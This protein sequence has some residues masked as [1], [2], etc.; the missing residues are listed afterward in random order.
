M[1]PAGRSGA[2]LSGRARPSLEPR[3]RN[4][5][6]DRKSLRPPVTG[7]FAAELVGNRDPRQHVAEAQARRSAG[8]PA[9][10]HVQSSGPR[11]SRPLPQ[12]RPSPILVGGEGAVFGRVGRE[13]VQQQS[14]AGDRGTGN[15]NVNSRD[16]DARMFGFVERRHNRADKRLERRGMGRGVTKPSE[17]VSAWAR[18][19]AESRARVASATSRGDFA[20][21][22]LKPTMLPERANRLLTR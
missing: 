10:R 7:D 22:A 2:F 11:R 6:A 3:S 20:E 18:A 19:S 9:A 21:R 14:E 12:R 15:A 13:F 4:R 5:E 1:A 17:K 16:R 8:R